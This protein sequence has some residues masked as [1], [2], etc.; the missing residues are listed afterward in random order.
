MNQPKPFTRQKNLSGN[1]QGKVIYA[2]RFSLGQ[3]PITILEIR[4]LIDSGKKGI[5]VKTC[6]GYKIMKLPERGL[7]I[8]V[9]NCFRSIISVRPIK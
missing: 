9:D 6:N 4:D 7:R 5:T 8:L 2:P 3:P 1:R